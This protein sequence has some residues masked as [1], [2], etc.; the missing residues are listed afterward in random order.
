[1]ILED[2]GFIISSMLFIVNP[3]H[4]VL[5]SIKFVNSCVTS[6]GNNHISSSIIYQFIYSLICRGEIGT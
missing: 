6:I 5:I 2:K 1:M 4:L 3:L